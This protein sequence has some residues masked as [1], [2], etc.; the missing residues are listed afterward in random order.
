MEVWHG[1][2]G[3]ENTLGKM[4]G[5]VWRYEIMVKGRYSGEVI[6]FG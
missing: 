4:D 5:K 2:M 1:S 6:V 3:K